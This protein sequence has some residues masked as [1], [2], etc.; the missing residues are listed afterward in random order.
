MRPALQTVLSVPIFDPQ[1]PGGTLLGTLQVDSDEG[2]QALGW[3]DETLQRAQTF[4]D[5]VA[6]H[7]GSPS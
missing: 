1:D 7:L 3:N 4:S 5:V 6:L 2:V